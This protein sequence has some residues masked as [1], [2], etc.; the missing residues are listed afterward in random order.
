[1]SSKIIDD[2]KTGVQG[3]RGAGDA[4]RGNLMKATDQAF[5]SGSSNNSNKRG[6]LG[7]PTTQA[8]E[9]KN[10]AIADKGKRDI[11][12]ADEMLARR[13]RERE[14]SKLDREARAAAGASARADA[15]A[16]AGTG[17]GVNTGVN[18]GVHSTGLAGNGAGASRGTGHHP[19]PL[20]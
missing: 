17:A 20:Q 19:L 18:P 4:L 11:D 3:I 15:G 1:M 12:A 13:E 6:A 7:D 9:L 8:A 10:Q 5:D 16:G 2:V 14:A